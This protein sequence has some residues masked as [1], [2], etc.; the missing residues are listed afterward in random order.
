[1]MSGV[2][3]L[4]TQLVF[5][6]LEGV[7]GGEQC[8]GIADKYFS[9][10]NSKERNKVTKRLFTIYQTRLYTNTGPSI[11]NSYPAPPRLGDSSLVGKTL[12]CGP[13]DH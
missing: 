7:F 8:P 6:D 2:T 12:V 11:K 9:P 1:M 5:T 13:D 4:L 3:T 10:A